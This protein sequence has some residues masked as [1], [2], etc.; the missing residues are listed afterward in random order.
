MQ[1]KV[2]ASTLL[3]FVAQT[4]ATPS[5]LTQDALVRCMSPLIVIAYASRIK[6]DRFFAYPTGHTTAVSRS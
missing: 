5:P 2:I 4:L 6:T 3:L 1:F